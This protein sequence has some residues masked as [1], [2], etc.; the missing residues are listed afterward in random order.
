MRKYL[1]RIVIAVAALSV[2][3][4]SVWASPQAAQQAKAPSYTMPEYNQF[5]SCQAEKDPTSKVKCLD[6][7]VKQFPNST[8]MQY[9]DEIYYQTYYQLKDYKN[10]IVYAD[11]LVALGDKADL[12]RR[13]QA[14]QAR[15]QLFPY[16]YNA[17]SPD[18]QDQLTKQRD[19]A[20]QGA[21]LLEQYKASPGS[22]LTDDQY[23]K[24]LAVF[25]AAAGYADLQLK[26]NTDAVQ[27]FKSALDNDPTDAVSEYRL[28]LAYLA[29]TPPDSLDGF[30]ALGRAVDL[31]VPDSDKVK[32]Y[33]RR[34]MLAYQQPGCV[35]QID[36][37]LNDLLQLAANSPLRPATWSIPSADD[38][39][40]IRN[41]DQASN[42]VSVITTLS[43]GGDNA[44]TTWLAICGAE[45]PEVVGKIIDENKSD[46]YV[47]FMIYSGATAAEMQ[48]ATTPNMDVKV[49][50]APP[51]PDA[52]PPAPANGAT[53]APA[54]TPQ[55]DVVRLKKDDGIR[56]SGTLV[57]YDASPFMLHWD[58]V[59]VDPSIIP[60][61]TPT[62]HGTRR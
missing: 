9:V 20:L 5:T 6:S 4:L 14:I 21:K 44:K 35:P 33:L 40:K 54:I 19:A 26:D 51:P 58:Q 10:A 36:P 29:L 55:P 27:A 56:F 45:Y 34:A 8:L 41:N 3:P 12:P 52:A 49:W 42:I 53:Q 28:G 39:N 48:A 30:W 59:K 13:V 32:D 31:K 25:Y 61:E 15:V 17:Q 60:K 57:S 2:V 11:K 38:L 7:F 37:Q 18:L 62:K 24:Y 50:I 1:N 22:K 47:D 16:A 46:S 43:A 23:K